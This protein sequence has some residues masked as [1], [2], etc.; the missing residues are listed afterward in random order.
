MMRTWLLLLAPALASAHGLVVNVEPAPPAVVLRA[1]YDNGEPAG[2]ADVTIFP[3]GQP[4]NAYQ[5]GS[6]DAQGVFAFVP[7]EPGA[8]TAVI[9]DGFGHRVETLVEWTS[10]G[11]APQ[12]AH[13]RSWRDAL[14]GVSL[15]IGLT[16]IW[17]WRKSQ[18]RP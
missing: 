12:Q 8:W 6:T 3:P 16:G 10:D 11:A 4:D 5:M 9:D 2:R 1:A 15:L 17:L 14:T 13:V 18:A 7:S